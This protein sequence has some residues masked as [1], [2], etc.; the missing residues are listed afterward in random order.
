MQAEPVNHHYDPTH[1]N[2]L[3]ETILQLLEAIPEVIA[4]LIVH[5]KDFVAGVGHDIIVATTKFRVR[6][7]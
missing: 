2:T 1:V 3:W 4:E 6:N 5:T 7:V